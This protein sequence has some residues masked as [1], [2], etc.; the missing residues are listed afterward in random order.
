[1]EKH[2]IRQADVARALESGR[3]G[4]RKSGVKGRGKY[5]TWTTQAMLRAS[6]L[7]PCLASLVVFGIAV[8]R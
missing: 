2:A 3:Y 7:A 8:E 6:F 1:M 5:K 4:R